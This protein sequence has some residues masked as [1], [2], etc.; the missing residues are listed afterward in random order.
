MHTA[1]QQENRVLLAAPVVLL[2]QGYREIFGEDLDC[3]TLH[4]AFK[5]PVNSNQRTDVNFTLNR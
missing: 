4:T 5:I 3:E 2:A 1:I